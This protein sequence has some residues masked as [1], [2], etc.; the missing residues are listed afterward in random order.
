LNISTSFEMVV[1]N[2]EEAEKAGE[3][4]FYIYEAWIKGFTEATPE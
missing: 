4:A 3:D 2:S 1:D